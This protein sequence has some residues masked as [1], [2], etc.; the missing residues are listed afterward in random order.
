[1]ADS[2]PVLTRWPSGQL[3]PRREE[4]EARLAGEGHQA[5]RMVDPPCTYY[6]DRVLARAETRWVLAGKLVVGLEDG[7]IELGIGDRI[8][9]PAGLRYWIRVISEDGVTYLL[10]PHRP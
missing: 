1:M 6:H 8:D 3:A 10:A 4:L 2:K 7:Q 9:L 5:Y